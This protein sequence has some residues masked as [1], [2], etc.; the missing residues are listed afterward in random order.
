MSDVAQLASK[1]LG[2]ED[3]IQEITHYQ[4]KPYD[5]GAVPTTQSFIDESLS[6]FGKTCPLKVGA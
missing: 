6:A 5:L 4:S 2:N 3:V 1:Q